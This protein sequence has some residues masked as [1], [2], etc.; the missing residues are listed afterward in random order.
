MPHTEVL[1]LPG[2][3]SSYRRLSINWNS[4]IQQNLKQPEKFLVPVHWIYHTVEKTDCHSISR[5]V[6]YFCMVIG[7]LL[8]KKEVCIY[9]LSLLWLVYCY[10]LCFMYTYIYLKYV[11]T[12]MYR[13][14]LTYLS[15][16]YVSIPIPFVPQFEIL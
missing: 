8:I 15:V 7:S 12:D 16:I 14:T 2:I 9:W 10:F 3:N 4:R 6:C 1:C 11:S 13:Y 5:K